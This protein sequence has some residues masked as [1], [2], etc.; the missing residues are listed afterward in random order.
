MPTQRDPKL[1][2][3]PLDDLELDDVGGTLAISKRLVG[4]D[5]EQPRSQGIV[6]AELSTMVERRQQAVG[7]D[8][9]GRGPV[10]DDEVGHGL[11]VPAVPVEQV[12]QHLGPSPS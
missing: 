1:G 8:V 9:L 3:G 2:D 10:T 6:V 5:P 7:Q 4:G 11:D 12:G